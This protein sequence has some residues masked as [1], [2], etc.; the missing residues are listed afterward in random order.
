[1]SDDSSSDSSNNSSNNSSSSSE[2]G[3]DALAANKKQ[4]TDGEYSHRAN[5]GA[6]NT[7]SS[8]WETHEKSAD[9]NPSGG[10]E[11]PSADDV[12][13][14]SS[15]DPDAP[16]NSSGDQSGSSNGSEEGE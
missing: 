15:V 14:P 3:R 2:T 16:A 5:A 6:K 4:S 9:K 13:I 11:V 7:D 10:N 8:N 12:S 1:M